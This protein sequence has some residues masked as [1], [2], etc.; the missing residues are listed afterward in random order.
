MRH[1]GLEAPLCF[2]RHSKS[3]GLDTFLAAGC[4]DPVF[5]ASCLKPACS[6]RTDVG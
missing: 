2:G 3:R 5:P 6:F 1:F 4:A